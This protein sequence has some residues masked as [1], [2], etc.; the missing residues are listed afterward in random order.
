MLPA[1]LSSYE[2]ALHIQGGCLA[3]CS[4]LLG[5]SQQEAPVSCEKIFHR[6]D[7]NPPDN[8]WIMKCVAKVDKL[9]IKDIT[10]NRGD[11][12]CP[13]GYFE[14]QP[15]KFAHEFSVLCFHKEDRTLCTDE[16]LELQFAT[17]NGNLTLVWDRPRQE[18]MGK[19]K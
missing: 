13:P 17:N 10:A 18:A 1:N 5:C 6:N 8:F 11:C 14:P 9:V 3:I 7:A 2:G 19:V 16:V 4:C 12:L 15:L